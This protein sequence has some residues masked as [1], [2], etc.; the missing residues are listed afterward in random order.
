MKELLLLTLGGH[1]TGNSS[2]VG[3]LDFRILFTKYI[4]AY[5]MLIG[6]SCIKICILLEGGL[7]CLAL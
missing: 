6:F 4:G 5:A 2:L 3:K 1:N 7:G